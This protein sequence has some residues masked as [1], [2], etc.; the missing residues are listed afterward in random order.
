MDAPFAL[1]VPFNVAEVYDTFKEEP[2]VTLG[3]VGLNV[4]ND[5]SLP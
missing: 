3:N 5:F 2:V 1:T 4:V